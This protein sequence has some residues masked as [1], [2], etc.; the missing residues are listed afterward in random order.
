[1]SYHRISWSLKIARFV[2]HVAVSLWKID[3]HH[4]STVVIPP[5]KFQSYRAA[6]NSLKISQDLAG[7]IG[8]MSLNTLGPKQNG[9]RFPDD[10]FQMHFLEWKYLN[11]DQNLTVPNVSDNKPLVQIMTWRLTGWRKYASLSLIELKWIEVQETFALI[12]TLEWISTISHH[13]RTFNHFA[14]FT[15]KLQTHTD[16]ISAAM[17]LTYS[18][19]GLSTRMAKRPVCWPFEGFRWQ[20]RQSALWRDF[21]HHCRWSNGI[22]ALRLA[23]Y[24]KIDLK[25][26]LTLL[27][28]IEI[29]RHYV[30]RC[31]S[32]LRCQ[33]INRN[34]VLLIRKSDRH[35]SNFLWLLMY[36]WFSILL[37]RTKTA[38]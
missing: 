10:F 34:S 25:K 21:I 3:K 2:I 26:F 16:E 1:M 8:G 38:A 19:S 15:N 18:Y 13:K 6:L 35:F 23:C 12:R 22:N 17:V 4:D 27:N 31:S 11:I 24:E 32:T 7:K 14:V 37:A 9:H 33:V 5:V 28:I 30:C 20:L 29:C 36:S